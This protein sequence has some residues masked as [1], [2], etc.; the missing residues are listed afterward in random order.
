MYELSDL[1][2]G[3]YVHISDLD[4]I[5]GVPI[6]LDKSTIDYS[7]GDPSGKIIFIGKGY[8]EVVDTKNI[9]VITNHYD[10]TKDCY[11]GSLIDND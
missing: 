10:A 1:K 11:D 8:S 9:V 5:V 2:V 4:S 7:T 6:V 3:M